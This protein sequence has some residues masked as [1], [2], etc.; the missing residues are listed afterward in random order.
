MYSFKIRKVSSTQKFKKYFNNDYTGENLY[1]LIMLL[2]LVLP[3]DEHS[4]L[5][6][7]I[8]D[9]FSRYETKFKTVKIEEIMQ[10]SG[11]KSN[12]EQI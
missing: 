8:K 3:K 5:I 6:L 7:E 4:H 11:F 12:W 2:K 1:D 10:L 9:I